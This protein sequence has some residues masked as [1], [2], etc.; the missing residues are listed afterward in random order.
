MPVHRRNVC[1]VADA[2][3][4]AD[5]FTVTAAGGLYLSTPSAPVRVFGTDTAHVFVVDS[6]LPGR[7]FAS[8]LLK[9]S[10][11]EEAHRPCTACHQQDMPS[12]LGPTLAESSSAMVLRARR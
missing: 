1:E 3:I 2:M 5:L 8:S 11:G 12:V 4:E 10:V 6:A 7:F 9:E